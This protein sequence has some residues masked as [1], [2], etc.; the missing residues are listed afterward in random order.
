MYKKLSV[1]A[2]ITA[3]LL[4]SISMTNIACG[5]AKGADKGGS[6]AGTGATDLLWVNLRGLDAK[7]GKVSPEL[8]KLDGQPVRIPG[9]AVPL[10]DDQEYMSEFLLV[11]YPRACIHVPAPPSNQIVHVRMAPGKSIKLD[12]WNP[13]WV[14]GR[15]K[16]AVSENALAK[17]SFQLA[18]ETSEPYKD[19][20]DPYY[21]DNP[22]VEHMYPDDQSDDY[23]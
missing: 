4:A 16:I 7:T 3:I 15:L 21:D 12:W 11:P 13:I 23:R 17:A 19:K 8:R 5:D 1:Y 14:R 10:E 18:G 2:R 6:S 9:F 22:P 20:K